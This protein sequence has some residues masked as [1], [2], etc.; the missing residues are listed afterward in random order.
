MISSHVLSLS[1]SLFVL[2]LLAPSFAPG[3]APDLDSHP[4]HPPLTH[5]HPPPSV[6]TLFQRQDGEDLAVKGVEEEVTT[7]AKLPLAG[8]TDLRPASPETAP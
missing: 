1:L 5:L 3:P 8:P 7:E 2:S 6:P 4:L